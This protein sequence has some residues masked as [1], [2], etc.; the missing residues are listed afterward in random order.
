MNVSLITG[1]FDPLHSGHLALIKSAAHIG[2][3]NL[4]C[5][6]LN[7]DAWLYRKKGFV[8]M[9]FE[10]RKEILE[11]IVSVHKVISF[12]DSD[13]S[14]CDAIE[15]CV[16]HYPYLEKIIFCNGGDRTE[17]NIPELDFKPRGNV[18]VEFAFGV[19]GTDKKNSSSALVKV[20][21]GGPALTVR[22]W[23]SWKVLSDDGTSKVKELS[24]LPGEQMSIQRH[25]KRNEYWLVS[26]GEFTAL[27]YREAHHPWPERMRET[28]SIILTLHDQY[29]VPINTWH[30]IK[31]HTDKVC[32]IIEIQY[33]SDCEEIDIE[34]H[35]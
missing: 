5:I 25:F 23:G 12:D 22:E 18:K 14:S 21:L 34:R 30:S 26:E 16:S 33:G 24:I 35:K 1:G 29:T 27:F 8:F 19:G 31:N 11:N 20:E 17:Q 3:Y 28:H 10:E 6:G 15:R 13:D 2:V 9:P 4:V 32:K 7:S